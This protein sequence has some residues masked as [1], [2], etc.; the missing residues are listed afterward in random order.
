MLAQRAGLTSCI[1][2]LL[3][4]DEARRSFVDALRRT[5]VELRILLVS[6]RLDAPSGVTLLHPAS[7]G[8]GLAALR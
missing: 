4:W 5:G 3:E 2:V 7:I 6:E 1:V 8:A